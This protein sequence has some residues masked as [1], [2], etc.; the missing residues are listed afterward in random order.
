[1]PGPFPR[2]SL[3]LRNARIAALALHD[4]FVFFVPFVVDRFVPFVVQ[5]CCSRS[6][7]NSRPSATYFGSSAT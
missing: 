1:M 5:L 3:R 2:G 7:S 4:F 6:A